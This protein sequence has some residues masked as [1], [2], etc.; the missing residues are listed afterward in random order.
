MEKIYVESKKNKEILDITDKVNEII[1]ESKKENG[2][3]HLFLP[4]STAGL[5]TSLIQPE[6]GLDLIDAFD[7]M[8]PITTDGSNKH[9]HSHITSRL[10]DHVISSFLGISLVIP[11]ENEKLALGEFQRII[12]VE[13]NGPRKRTVV[14]YYE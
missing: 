9:L 7:V 12:L 13:L 14:V 11:I 6:N 10:P 1:K 4:H 5:T 3:C 2:L 8:L